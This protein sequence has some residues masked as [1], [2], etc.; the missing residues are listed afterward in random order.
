MFCWFM[1]VFVRG[2]W[3]VSRVFVFALGVGWC[4]LTLGIT[5]L[6]WFGSGFGG[7][8]CVG[9]SC[10]VAAVYTFWFGLFMVEL[11]RLVA[12]LVVLFSLLLR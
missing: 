7:F 5:Y 8:V 3:L 6:L 10:V 1:V 11:F 9:V 2:V 4:C 12:C